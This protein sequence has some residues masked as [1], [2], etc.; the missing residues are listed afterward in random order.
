M[1]AGDSQQFTVVLAGSATGSQQI[2]FKLTGTQDVSTPAT[3]VDIDVT[4]S[5]SESP[6]SSQTILYS[7]IGILLVAVLLFGV[8]LARS[9]KRSGIASLEQKVMP[10]ITQ[11]QPAVMCWSCHGPITGPMQGCPGCG[12]RY[13]TKGTENCDAQS[14]EACANC[15]ASAE[16]FVLA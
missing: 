2:T 14:L 13:H 4:A 6:S 7:S 12:A 16:Q 9:K 5:F 3:T 11:Q 1:V 15:G 8:I 10:S